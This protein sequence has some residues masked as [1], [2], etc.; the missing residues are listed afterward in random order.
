MKPNIKE[1]IKEL[2]EKSIDQ[3][4]HETA[5]KWL[6]RACAAQTLNLGHDVTEYAHEAMEHAALTPGEATLRTVRQTMRKYKIRI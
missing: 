4:Q 1:A 3:I 5:M 2:R 6:A